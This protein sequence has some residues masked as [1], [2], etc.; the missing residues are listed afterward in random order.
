MNNFP[1]TSDMD[2]DMKLVAEVTAR[3]H[4]DCDFEP[5]PPAQEIC[6][7]LNTS[8]LASLQSEEGHPGI[9]FNWQMLFLAELFARRSASR[10]L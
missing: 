4:E 7:V 3:F 9:S 8:I 5:A 2:P 6:G 1:L 10:H